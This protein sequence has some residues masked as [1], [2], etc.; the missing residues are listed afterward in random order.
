MLK[1]GSLCPLL[2]A[3]LLSVSV[4]TVH[5]EGLYPGDGVEGIG[6]KIGS[7]T[8]KRDG[9]SINIYLDGFF[10]ARSL[11][12]YFTDSDTFDQTSFGNYRAHIELEMEFNTHVSL[13]TGFDALDQFV[14]GRNDALGQ[15][16]SQTPTD[17]ALEVPYLYGGYQEDSTVALTTLYGRLW[18]DFGTFKIGRMPL[19]WGLGLFFNDGKDPDSEFTTRQDRIFYQHRVANWE[20]GTW[21]FP[22]HVAASFGMIGEGN[23]LSVDD[24]VHEYLAQ[25]YLESDVFTNGFM[26]LYRTSRDLRGTTGGNNAIRLDN[27]DLF[28]INWQN[29]LYLGPFGIEWEA[30]YTTGTLDFAGPSR[31]IPEVSTFGFNFAGRLTTELKNY[32]NFIEYGYSAGGDRNAIRFSQVGNVNSLGSLIGSTWNYYPFNP[33][34][35]VDLLMFRELL[36]AVTAATVLPFDD[37]R[38]SVANAQYVRFGSDYRVGKMMNF[39]DFNVKSN[40][41][42]ARLNHPDIYET[43]GVGNI[44]KDLGIEFDIEFWLTKKFM[45]DNAYLGTLKIG[46]LGGYLIGGDFFEDL[47]L[48]N[49]DVTGTGPNP[50]LDFFDTNDVW[51]VQGQFVYKF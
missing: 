15:I 12:Y 14:G 6:T 37:T 43:F 38:G 26:F 47:V 32:S 41:I 7:I 46:L 23:T 21:E 42:W 48:F 35:H 29:K 33:N 17:L 2:V 8:S 10:R 5:G 24:D 44:D 50:G 4:V 45:R 25:V 27:Q 34:Y 3:F 28:M 39:F 31:E 18:T 30:M 1:F 36:S 51:T 19:N 16:L 9:S 49:G 40:V 13:F 22:L 11:N 20:A